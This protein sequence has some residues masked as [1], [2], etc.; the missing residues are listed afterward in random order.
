MNQ[1]SQHAVMYALVHSKHKYHNPVSN[2]QNKQVHK[3]S[4]SPLDSGSFLKNYSNGKHV[5]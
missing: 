2:D 1:G 3:N 5:V 4:L